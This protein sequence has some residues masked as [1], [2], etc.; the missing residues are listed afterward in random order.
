ML[1]DLLVMLDSTYRWGGE[2][3]GFKSGSLQEVGSFSPRK[4]TL[5]M[6]LERFLISLN[7]FTVNRHFMP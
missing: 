1:N 5:Q 4:T 6:I 3:L 7:G 2:V